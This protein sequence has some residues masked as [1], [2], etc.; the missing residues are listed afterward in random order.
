M[1]G[2]EHKINNNNIFLELRR[3]TENYRLRSLS[4]VRGRRDYLQAVSAPG[5]SG[6]S[7]SR[8]SEV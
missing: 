4:P 6:V 8:G 5:N 1:L 7:R 3:G 2:W